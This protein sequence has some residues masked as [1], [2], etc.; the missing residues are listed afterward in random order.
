MQKI[1]FESP[2]NKL[3]KGYTQALVRKVSDL[4][5]EV[6]K[7]RMEHLHN[8]RFLSALDKSSVFEKSHESSTEY[9]TV[10]FVFDPFAFLPTE[11][12]KRATSI[13]CS[14]CSDFKK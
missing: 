6:L 10:N 13:L 5:W 4:N 14:A 7:G 8:N 12:R 1:D 3:N 11:Y 9:S 2:K